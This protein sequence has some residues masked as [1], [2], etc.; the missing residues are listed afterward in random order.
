MECVTAFPT[1]EPP[2]TRAFYES[3]PQFYSGSPSMNQGFSKHVKVSKQSQYIVIWPVGFNRDLLNI[4]WLL[5]QPTEQS[6]PEVD[7]YTLIFKV[8]CM[9]IAKEKPD[10]KACS[11]QNQIWCWGFSDSVS[12]WHVQIER[13]IKMLSLMYCYINQWSSSSS[14]L[15][16]LS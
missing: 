2:T 16:L 13:L 10:N 5:I 7:L 6:E 15:S 8:F 11:S 4:H 14:S 3:D 1:R 9:D 12:N